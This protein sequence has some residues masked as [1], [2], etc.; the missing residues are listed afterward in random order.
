MVVRFLRKLSVV[1]YALATETKNEWLQRQLFKFS[2][3][4]HISA[5]A[6][7]KGISFRAAAFME[8]IKSISNF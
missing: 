8:N 2:N 5:V 1:T 6:R 3:H 7:E 4:C